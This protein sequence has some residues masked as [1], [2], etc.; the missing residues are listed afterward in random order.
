[1]R[2]KNLQGINLY[3][4][5]IFFS[6]NYTSTHKYVPHFNLLPR[7]SAEIIICLRPKFLP[8][9]IK[10]CGLQPICRL[11]Y[12]YYA[13][14]KSLWILAFPAITKVPI[15]IASKILQKV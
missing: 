15:S 10:N 12:I 4:M 2:A 6:W 11:L 13:V 3:Q 9:V 7:T 8:E 5:L 1:M 14:R